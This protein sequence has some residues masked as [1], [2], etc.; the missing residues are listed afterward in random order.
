MDCVYCGQKETPV[1][2]VP[3]P[4]PFSDCYCDGCY[5]A[6][7]AQWQ[8]FWYEAIGHKLKYAIPVRTPAQP[9]SA[10]RAEDHAPMP[11]DVSET[12]VC[13]GNEFME[14]GWL[15]AQED[16]IM[17]QRRQWKA[18]YVVKESDLLPDPPLNFEI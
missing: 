9:I 13:D 18:A 15:Q 1:R 10:R 8:R 17:E 3:A 16:R 6:A 12:I 4:V 2:Q 11:D 5:E 14:P 7:R